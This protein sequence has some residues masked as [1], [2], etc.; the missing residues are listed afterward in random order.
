MNG[1]PEMRWLPAPPEDWR[2]RARALSR[3]RGDAE[4]WTQAVA[5][6]SHRASFQLTNMLATIVGDIFDAPP[7]SLPAPPERLAVLSSATTT[8]LLPALKIAAMR[9]GL[10]LDTYENVYG[11]YRQELLDRNSALHAFAPTSVLFALDA[12]HVAAGASECRSREEAAARVESFV[13]GLVDLWRLARDR[14]GCKLLQQ[15]ILPRAPLLLGSNEHRHPASAA[16]FIAAVN[17]RL[18]EACD[19]HG[20]DLLG[21]DARVA[22]DGLAAWHSPAFWLKAK[23]EIALPAAPMYGELV[24]RLLAARLGRSA[25]ACVLDLDNTLWGGVIGD[26]GPDGVVIGQ[27]SAQGEAFLAM[28]K[29]ALDLRRRGI[30]LAVCS[31]ND[32]AVARSAFEKNPEMALKLSDFGCFIANWDDKAS[33]LREIARRLNIG[34]DA[35]VFVD[36]N[37]FERELVRRELPMVAVPELPPEPELYVSCL[38]D[39]G[40]FEGVALTSE[41]FAR[42]S[43]YDPARRP[44]DAG[45]SATDLAAYLASLDMRL[46][47]GPV[48]ESNLERTVQLINKTNQFNL[49]T[50]RY[51]EPELRAIMAEPSCRCLQFR[52]LDRFGDNGLISVVILRASAE[53]GALEID[54]WL[55]SC[56]VLGRQVE[57]AVLNVIVDHAREAGALRL[58]GVYR[59]TSKNA[60]V[61]RHYE[62][63]GFAPLSESADE[64]RSAL[65]L[66]SAAPRETF[67]RICE[68][69]T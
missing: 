29:Y 19:T 45:V 51:S 67:I 39:S 38:A 28:Q 55:M 5:L 33:N 56:R 53:P 46:V 48:D 13:A 22:L 69:Q 25:K 31:K 40:Y 47:F 21:I 59:R 17:H 10:W 20:V 36:D 26:D 62:K 61:A 9:R 64:T 30:I 54:V 37:P 65:D 11:L 3:M 4:A 2:A 63:L 15:A 34:V 68:A 41:D 42:A 44:P 50:R 1:G 14:F 66:E 52:L 12:D 16:A 57:E 60:M 43:F 58:V 27:G 24:A 35:L 8:H 23:Q 7:E 6:A 32:E 49:T 18:R